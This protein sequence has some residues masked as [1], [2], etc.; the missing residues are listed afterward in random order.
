MIVEIL[1]IFYTVFG[2]FHP[3]NTLKMGSFIAQLLSLDGTFVKLYLAQIKWN[4]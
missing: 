3:D 4:M 1:S 2:H